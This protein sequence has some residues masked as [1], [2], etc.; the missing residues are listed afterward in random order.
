VALNPHSE[1]PDLSLPEDYKADHPSEHPTDWG[2]H[3][4]WGRAARIGGYVVVIITVV[5]I[6]A[7]HYNNSGTLWLLV[8]A[9]GLLVMLIRD[10]LHRRNSWRK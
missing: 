7:T 6:T 5:M 3:G 9:A 4:E 1:Q 10:V 8:V 2:W